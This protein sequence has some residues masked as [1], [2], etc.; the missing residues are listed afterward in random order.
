M[1]SPSTFVCVQLNNHT[2]L[3]RLHKAEDS[4]QLREDYSTREMEN[5]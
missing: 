4:M 5:E 3:N 2:Q 1:Y